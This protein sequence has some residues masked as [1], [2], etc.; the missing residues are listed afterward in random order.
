MPPEPA[1]HLQPVPPLAEARAG[2]LPV[3]AQAEE[4]LVARAATVLHLRQQV[5]RPPPARRQEL[6][7]A[8]SL[9][10]RDQLPATNRKILRT[11]RDCLPY[12]GVR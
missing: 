7:V 12:E 5:R 10:D 6:P 2:G 1:R 11:I 4:L 3:V 9:R 8:E